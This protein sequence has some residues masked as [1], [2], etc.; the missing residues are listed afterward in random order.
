MRPASCVSDPDPLQEMWIRIRVAKKIVI[1]TL[2][3]LVHMNNKLIKN[4]QKKIIG[5]CLSD[6]LFPEADPQILFRI[7]M[8]RIRNT[9]GIHNILTK[10]KL[11]YDMET[12]FVSSIKKYFNTIGTLK[13]RN[14]Y[15]SSSF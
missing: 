2:F 1:N 6:P 14:K 11:I 9:A 10:F 13:N 5:I 15:H 8:E 7:K 12:G 4:I 3:C